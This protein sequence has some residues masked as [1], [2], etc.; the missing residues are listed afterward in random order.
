MGNMRINR[1]K[2]EIEVLGE[3]YHKLCEENPQGS[4]KLLKA[5]IP[6]AVY[7]FNA[8][9]GLKLPLKEVRNIV[10]RG[11][12]ESA[13]KVKDICLTRNLGA[14]M[15]LA[16]DDPSQRLS[17]PLILGLHKQYLTGVN[18]AAAGQ[19]RVDNRRAG[20]GIEPGIGPELAYNLL[21]DLVKHY[22]DDNRE[23]L[24][25]IA[26]F[27]A[28]F[29]AL[30]PFPEGNEQIGWALVARHFM[31]LG[32]PP[33]I[34]Y[35]KGGSTEYQKLLKAYRRTGNCDELTIFFALALTEALNKYVTILD[36][37]KKAVVLSKWAKKHELKTA[38]AM[39]RAKRQ[40]IPAFRQNG[41]W[42]IDK[43]YV[44]EV[45]VEPWGDFISTPIQ[46]FT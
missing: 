11:K 36:S 31:A 22:N 21:E 6:E 34:I 5:E 14:V 9:G 12:V 45:R 42:Q 19:L 13:A 17:V 8:L 18:D 28:E 29:M 43:D 24:E 1:L 41:R 7:N 27:H 46:E 16:T 40:S 33:V 20:N 3:K 25:K 26:F 32:F 4:E 38:S 10:L 35:S 15:G 44:P 39:N 2:K 30:K 23:F 37:K